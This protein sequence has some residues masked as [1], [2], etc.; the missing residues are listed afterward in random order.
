MFAYTVSNFDSYRE[1][2]LICLDLFSFYQIGTLWAFLPDGK[3]FEESRCSMRFC[4]WRECFNQW[5]TG[6]AMIGR[7]GIV[8]LVEEDVYYNI[9]FLNWTEDN[10]YYDYGQ[11]KMPGGGFSYRRDKEPFKL[12]NDLPECPKCETAK[13]N[14]ATL[15]GPQDDTFVEV[16]IEGITPA[17]KVQIQIKGVTQEHHPACN[18]RLTDSG[19]VIPN[20]IRNTTDTVMLRRTRARGKLEHFRYT[21]HF[22]AN[23]EAGSCMGQVQV[24]VPAPGF[25]NCDAYPYGYDAAATKYCLN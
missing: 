13:A 24:C 14:P 15:T 23:S 16:S 1:S 6:Q 25:D 17:D 20:A 5:G 7:P 19:G 22:N 11:S 9:E 3:T 10:P 21:V 2:F 12:P 4:S 8:H 18:T